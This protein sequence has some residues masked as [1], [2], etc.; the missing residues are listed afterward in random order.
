MPLFRA[1]PRNV[2]FYEHYEALF[3][4]LR[5][6]GINCTYYIDDSLY[7]DNSYDKLEIHTQRAMAPLK[8][9]GFT[10]NE[11]KSPITPSTQVTHLG[12][13]VDSST[14]TISLPNQKIERIESE[15]NLILAAKEITIRQFSK[16]I[17]SFVSSFLAVQ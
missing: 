10:M 15:C 13:V 5:C 11:E 6:E 2:L 7:L 3:S 8:S 16:L 1:K 9:L 4:Q 17:G 14:Y 12:F